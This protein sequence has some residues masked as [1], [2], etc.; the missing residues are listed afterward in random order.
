MS[1]KQGENILRHRVSKHYSSLF[2]AKEWE[3]NNKICKL[4]DPTPQG[5]FDTNAEKH[6][7]NL[8]AQTT[9]TPHSVSQSCQCC[10]PF[11][12]VV[13][14][15]TSCMYTWR[16]MR[17][18]RTREMHLWD[19]EPAH[20]ARAPKKVAR[21]H[22]PRHFFSQQ[23]FHRLVLRKIGYTFYHRERSLQEFKTRPIPRSN[24]GAEILVPCSNQVGYSLRNYQLV[25]SR[26]VPKRRATW[27][28]N[29]SDHKAYLLMH[30]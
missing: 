10:F 14:R 27:L 13:C 20:L 28:Q 19:S 9:N 15:C 6:F 24:K 26:H 23:D 17:V 29:Q 5:S 16:H 4:E 12:A 3:Q 18:A 11:M 7:C 22:A 21:R 25:H 30:I 1:N 2:R 8:A